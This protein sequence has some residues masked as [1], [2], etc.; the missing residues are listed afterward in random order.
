MKIS[1]LDRVEKVRVEM[2]GAKDAYKQVPL[3]KKDGVPTFSFRV[4]TIEPN[5]HTP[6]HKHPFEHLNYVIEGFGHLVTEEAK[7]R[8]VKE[9]DFV[10]VLPNEQHQYKNKSS[11]NPL[12]MIFAVPKEYE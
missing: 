9:G 12:I 3:S 6:F 11:K 2:E 10:L 5:G 8:E 4:F 7:E 1:S